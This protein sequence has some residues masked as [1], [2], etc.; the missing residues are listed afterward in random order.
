MID[1]LRYSSRTECNPLN[2]FSCEMLQNICRTPSK[3]HMCRMY[4]YK[5][6]TFQVRVRGAHCLPKGGF[7]PGKSQ[8]DAKCS[9][10]ALLN[11]TQTD[12]IT[13]L[14]PIQLTSESCTHS[15]AT[16]SVR[17]YIRERRTGKVRTQIACPAMQKCSHQRGGK[18]PL[19][20]R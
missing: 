5:C 16:T 11:V 2:K 15:P 6:G 12:A 13:N 4:F 14:M 1:I 17:R 19:S 8:E 20:P 18:L 3:E 7:L 10:F 9:S